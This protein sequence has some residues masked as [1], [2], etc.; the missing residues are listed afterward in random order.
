MIDVQTS[1]EP[2]VHA[3]YVKLADKKRESAEIVI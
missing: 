3:L 1:E 2:P